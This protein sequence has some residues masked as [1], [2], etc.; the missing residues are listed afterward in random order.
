MSINPSQ[1][2]RGDLV[3]LAKRSTTSY[4]HGPNEEQ[5]RVELGVAT[6]V[7]RDGRV[8]AWASPGFGDQTSPDSRPLRPGD[9]EVSWVSQDRVDVPVVLSDYRQ[10][11]YPGT[12]SDMVMPLE[13]LEQTKALLRARRLE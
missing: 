9:G 7:S 3:V 10:R 6:S 12:D 13:S 11:R 4:V 2:R 1:P 8:K 5:V